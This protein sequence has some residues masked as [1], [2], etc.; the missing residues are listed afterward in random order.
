MD[1]TSLRESY[2]RLIW[3]A[4]QGPFRP[5]ADGEWSA[6]LVL[7]H[8]TAGDRLLCATAAEILAGRV[9]NHD[10]RPAQSVPYLQ[11]IVTAA[12][13]SGLLVETVRRGGEELA[14]LAAQLTAEQASA[15]VHVLIVDGGEVRLDGPL[16]L[17]RLL[18]I[19]AGSHLPGHAEQ[20]QS[21]V[22]GQA[23]T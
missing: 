10:A 19:H 21:L 8:V 1:V 14:E 23:I 13:D 6:E 16:A 17:G 5:P 7:A 15:E 4:R 2:G 12:E 9:P 20:L 18:E 3:A 22:K 11:S